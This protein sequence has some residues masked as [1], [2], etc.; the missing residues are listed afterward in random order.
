MGNLGGKVERRGGVNGRLVFV[1]CLCSEDML[2]KYLGCSEVRTV[3]KRERETD[4][5]A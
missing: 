4:L 2:W 3:S 1:T 5:L